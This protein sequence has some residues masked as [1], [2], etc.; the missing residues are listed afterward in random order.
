MAGTLFV[1]A[2]PIGN[3]EDITLRALRVL[4]EV[5]L[6]ACEDTRHTR[7][8]LTHYEISKPTCSYHEHNEVKRTETL[9]NHLQAGKNVALVCNAGT[10]LISDPGYRI[11]RASLEKGIRVS[12]IPGACSI[13]SALSVSGRPTDSF[14]FIGFLPSKRKARK[15][16]LES[17]RQDPRTLLFFESPLRLIGV[18]DDIEKVL[19]PRMV[20]VVREMTKIYEEVIMGSPKEIASLFQNHPPKG[21]IVL[22][23]EK[24]FDKEPK[25]VLFENAQLYVRLNELRSQG[26]SKREIAKALSREFKYSKRDLY[27]WLNRGAG[28]VGDRDEF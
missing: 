2:T 12:P 6:I 15:T 27:S 26:L 1:V 5:D 25:T 18:M 13:I 10:P 17:F 16:V 21:E 24:S 23:I 7:K 3:M 19:G 11:V 8:L 4:R 9:I 22:V 28:V 14:T 20:T